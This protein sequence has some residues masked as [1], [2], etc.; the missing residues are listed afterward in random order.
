MNLTIDRDGLVAGIR[1]IASP[2]FDERPASMPIDLVVIHSISLPPGEFGGAGIV[3]LFTNRLDPAA[4]PYYCTIATLKVSAHFL[5]RRDGELIQFV[6]CEKRAW[7]AGES[8]WRGRARCN[9][10]SVG[11]ELEGADDQPFTDVQYEA[12]GRLVAAVCSHYKVAEVVGHSDIAPQRKTDPGPCFD[13]P[14]FR[15]LV[16]SA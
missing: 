3:D 4:H 15:E 5:V 16:K 13:W 6:P 2:N 14:R 10:Y 12:L 8:T 11:I 1:Y 7:H 9:D